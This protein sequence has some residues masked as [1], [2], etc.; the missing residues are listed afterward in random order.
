MFLMFNPPNK[1]GF[2]QG[3]AESSCASR[4]SRTT[5]SLRC[6]GP[7]VACQLFLRSWCGL[8]SPAPCDHLPGG[9]G[10]GLTWRSRFPIDQR[11]AQK[12]RPNHLQTG[13]LFGNGGVLEVRCERARRAPHSQRPTRCASRLLRVHNHERAGL[14]KG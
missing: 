6:G 5:S 11:S 4:S 1:L 14:A 7:A 12:Q 13:V 10:M 9:T 8:S 2:L 3:R